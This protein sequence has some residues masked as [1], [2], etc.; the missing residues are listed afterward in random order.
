[1]RNFKEGIALLFLFLGISAALKLD[2]S[3]LKDDENSTFVSRTLRSQNFDN[4]F[5]GGYRNDAFRFVSIGFYCKRRQSHTFALGPCSSLFVQCSNDGNYEFQ[6][7]PLEQIFDGQ[8]C[9]PA[10]KIR[11]C[12][13]SRINALNLATEKLASATEACNNGPGIQIS[14]SKDQCSRQALLCDSFRE[15]RAISCP[16][17]Q[18]LDSATLQC[19]PSST[20]QWAPSLI[21]DNLLRDYCKYRPISTPSYYP[22]TNGNDQTSSRCQNW[23]VSCRD[24]EFIFCDA[25]KIF[26]KASSGCRPPLPQ[27]RCPTSDICRGWEWRAIP[28]G[29][30]NPQFRYCEGL[31]SRIFT[32]REDHVFQDKAC[33]PSKSARGCP[34]CKQGETKPTKNCRQ[35]FECQTSYGSQLWTLKTCPSNNFYNRESRRCELIRGNACADFQQ[36]CRDGD[37]YNPSC[38]DYLLCREGEFHPGKCPHL[39]R[40]N[41]QTL[42]C[43]PDNTCRRYDNSNECRHGDIIPT[44]DCQTYFLCDKGQ[45]VKRPCKE[46]LYGKNRKQFFYL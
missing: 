41:K 1:M 34:E 29:E 12:L 37:S 17:G 9:V 10:F 27:E 36:T 3:L 16:I 44:V 7:C 8:I 23:F 31:K 2:N 21:K 19:L 20:C 30:C 18:I 4:N 46:S 35:F 32:C 11:E 26:D 39:T 45:F 33:I 42:Q 40:W 43:I 15:P 6:E 5:D 13:D 38:G 14:T 24:K 28:L 22:L 25:G